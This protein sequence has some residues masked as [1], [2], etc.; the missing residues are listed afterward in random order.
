MKNEKQN[1]VAVDSVLAGLCGGVIFFLMIISFVCIVTYVH[2]LLFLLIAL[3][4]LIIAGPIFCHEMMVSVYKSLADSKQKPSK[5]ALIVIWVTFL[6][7][8][9]YIIFI[10]SL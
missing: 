10:L 6:L 9:S 7:F 4:G 8:L 1:S 5:R 2:S 3:A